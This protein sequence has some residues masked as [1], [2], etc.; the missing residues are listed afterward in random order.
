MLRKSKM[1]INQTTSHPIHSRLTSIFLD[2]F[3]YYYLDIITDHSAPRLSP[4]KLRITV[5]NSGLKHNSC[6]FIYWPLKSFTVTTHVCART[7]TNQW[8]W[9][10]RYL[11]A[12][13]LQQ[14]L[15]C[16]IPPSLPKQRMP[17]VVSVLV[18][19]VMNDVCTFPPWDVTATTMTHVYNV[20]ISLI[21]MF[22]LLF[23]M[24]CAREKL[25]TKLI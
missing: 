6:S 12:G 2:Q 9:N 8:D 14:M 7:S 22:F 13:F 17:S 16:V 21:F 11:F 23:Q 3:R 18:G 1:V 19:Y 4:A 10:Y 24:F 15:Q 25:P 20:D 5:Q